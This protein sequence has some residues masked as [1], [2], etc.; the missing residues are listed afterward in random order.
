V[1]FIEMII[2]IDP[3]VTPSTNTSVASPGGSISLN[4]LWSHRSGMLLSWQ[5]SEGNGAIALT[6]SE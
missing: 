2:I 1:F 6:F 5:S 3:G 4:L